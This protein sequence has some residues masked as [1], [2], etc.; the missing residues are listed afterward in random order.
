MCRP[1]SRGGQRVV[2]T[3]PMLLVHR[4][5]IVESTVA[6]NKQSKIYHIPGGQF[7]RQ[8]TTTSKDKVCFG[9]ETEAERAGYRKPK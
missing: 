2:L 9:S 3:S 6:G 8:T 5:H 4:T 7:Y 1:A